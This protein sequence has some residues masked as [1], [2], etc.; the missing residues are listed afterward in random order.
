MR[1]WI[2]GLFDIV[3]IGD[4][5]TLEALWNVPKLR[6]GTHLGLSK[7]EPYA[8]AGCKVT[9]DENVLLEMDGIGGDAAVTCESS[10]PSTL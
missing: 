8:T 10:R 4:F 9:S 1:R 5:G 6:N 3:N 7:G 2:D